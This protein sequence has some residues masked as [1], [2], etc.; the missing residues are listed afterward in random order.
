M[1]YIPYNIIN[2]TN[3]LGSIAWE[4]NRVNAFSPTLATP[5][6]ACASPGYFYTANTPADITASLNAMFDQALRVA[7]LTQ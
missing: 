4:N 3:N 2:F 1:L 7:R 6:R 5:L